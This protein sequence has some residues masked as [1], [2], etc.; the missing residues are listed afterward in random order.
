MVLIEMFVLPPYSNP[1][2]TGGFIKDC[3]SRLLF[4]AKVI[5]LYDMKLVN[6]KDKLE[7]WLKKTPTYFP[8]D[9]H[10]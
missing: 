8:I 3:Y 4:F 9:R 5:F 6:P 2:C 10:N 1:R 7:L